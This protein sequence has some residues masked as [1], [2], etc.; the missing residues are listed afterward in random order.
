MTTTQE[1]WKDVVDAVGKYQVSNQGRVRKTPK[2]NSCGFEYGGGIMSMQVNDYMDYWH[3]RL[4][5]IPDDGKTYFVHVLVAE[6]FNG[7]RPLWA[8]CVNHINGIKT[9]NRPENLE[10]STFQQNV[11]HAVDTGLCKSLKGEDH[12]MA[13]M[14]NE[15]VREIRRMYVEN[16]DISAATLG[17]KFGIWQTTA[18]S[19]IGY[20][21]WSNVDPENRSEYLGQVAAKKLHLRR[22]VSKANNSFGVAKL[23]NEQVLEIRRMWAE[24]QPITKRKIARQFSIDDSTCADVINRKIHNLI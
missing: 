17:E 23:T 12:K 1:V 16:L 6:A 15:T 19:I 22:I 9:D 24:E 5:L 2:K 8:E 10:W 4:R 18:N 11:Q 13:K 3:I 21:T 7:P 14:T 20:R